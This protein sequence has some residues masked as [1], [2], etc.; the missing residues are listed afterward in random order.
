GL[1]PALRLG[2][3]NVVSASL[4]FIPLTMFISVIMP[5]NNI[6][7]FGDLATI[8]FFV[9]MGVAVH[10]GNLFRTIISGSLIMAGTLWIAT[11]TI[12]YLP[13]LGQ[14]TGQV[15]G[16]KLLGSLVQGSS[17]ITYLLIEGL[18]MK[19]VAG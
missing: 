5:D 7:P 19:N 2:Q 16:D 11:Q 4:L 9:A 1:D 18:T 6:L 10:R 8:S 13:Q 12:P 3:A 15:S 17:P 14:F